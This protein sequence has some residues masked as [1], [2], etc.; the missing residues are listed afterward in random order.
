MG[1]QAF[2]SALEGGNCPTAKKFRLEDMMR[3]DISDKMADKFKSGKFSSF[4]TL[5]LNKISFE[6]YDIFLF[7]ILYKFILQIML[8]N[9]G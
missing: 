1:N 9:I 8:I 4:L 6:R 2:I 7:T 5:I 3:S